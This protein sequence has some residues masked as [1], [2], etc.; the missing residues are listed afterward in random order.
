MLAPH[1]AQRTLDALDGNAQTGENGLAGF[2]FPPVAEDQGR[3][4]YLSR[5]SVLW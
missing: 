5:F 3:L 4:G 1:I 2:C